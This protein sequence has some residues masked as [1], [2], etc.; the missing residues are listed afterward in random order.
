MLQRET[1]SNLKLCFFQIQQTENL[2]AGRHAVHGNMEKG[3]Q[4]PHGDK[5]IRC[6][7]DNQQTSLKGNASVLVLGHRHND[8]QRRAAVSD[9]VH[10]GDGV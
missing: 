1:F 6:Q 2:V 9:Q 8:A 10:N 4:L 7:Q 3:A 5:E